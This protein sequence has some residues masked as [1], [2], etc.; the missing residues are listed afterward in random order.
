[1]MW[2][3]TDGSSL[4]WMGAMMILFWGGAIA[5]IAFAARA[6]AKGRTGDPAM[7]ILRGRLAS[8]ELSQ[9]DFDKTR[10]ALRG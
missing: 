8:G 6:F 10:K 4:V 7:E 9:E 3:Y 5:L 1:M 2:G